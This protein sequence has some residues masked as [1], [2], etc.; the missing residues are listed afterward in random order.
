MEYTKWQVLASSLLPSE[1]Q[2]PVFVLLG[3]IYGEPGSQGA[4]RQGLE[5]AQSG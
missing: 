3:I 2:A 5:H 4:E 1:H